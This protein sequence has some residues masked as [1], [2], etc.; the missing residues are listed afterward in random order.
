MAAEIHAWKKKGLSTLN[1][2]S[3]DHHGIRKVLEKR[4]SFHDRG[5]TYGVIKRVS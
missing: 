4:I 2:F 1:G 5:R 3:L